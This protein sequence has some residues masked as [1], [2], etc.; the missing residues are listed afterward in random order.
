MAG[1]S[2]L[3][4][5]DVARGL[6]VLGMFGAHLLTTDDLVWS[7]PSS[8]DGLVDGR[9]SILFAT[10]AGV[11]V[12][13]LTGRTSPPT[14]DALVRARLVLLVRAVLVFAAGSAVQLLITPVGVILEYYAVL[15][16]LAVPLLR[17]RPRSLFLLAGG[18]VVVLN[19]LV[20]LLLVPWVSV[21]TGGGG[22]LGGLV[23]LGQYPVA[24]WVAF[25]VVGLGVGRLDL[26]AV[27]VR[28]GLVVVGLVGAVVGYAAGPVLGVG[29][30]AETFPETALGELPR[31]QDL[32]PP[33]GQLLSTAPHS[34]TPAEVV[35][36]GGFALAVLGVCL[37]VADRLR[38]VLLP[39]A[40][41]GSMP[42]SAYCLQLVGIALLGDSVFSTADGG[43]GHW[44][45]FAGTALVVCTV[46]SQT[47]GRGPLERGIGLVTARALR[48]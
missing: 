23:L 40:A 6:A 28:V 25:L 26:T 13:L 8:W 36:S 3:V 15:F 47:L 32:V 16:V 19:P 37:L 2:R 44:V 43:V 21:E 7:D 9:S 11:S 48:G 33:V 17:W 27:R 38:R 39:L 1:R 46:W 34:G 14:G 12:A 20:H 5:V 35:A 18:V 45:L 22:V 4:G 42:L 24:I 31:W 41:V 30:Q 10:L 29:E